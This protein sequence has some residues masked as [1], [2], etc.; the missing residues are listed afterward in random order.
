MRGELYDAYWTD[1]F[2]KLKKL[3][4]QAP[5]DEK[6]AKIMAAAR[7]RDNFGRDGGRWG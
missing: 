4:E 7:R 3:K 5:K 6:A 2:K 1:Y